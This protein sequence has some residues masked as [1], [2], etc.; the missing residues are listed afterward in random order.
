MNN[1]K[2]LT[3]LIPTCFSVE[4]KRLVGLGLSATA[5]LVAD[6]GLYLEP[7]WKPDVRIIPSHLV[8]TGGFRKQI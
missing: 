4:P 2:Y 3:D 6:L 5:I 8:A 1:F 7:S